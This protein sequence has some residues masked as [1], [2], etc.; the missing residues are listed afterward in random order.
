MT[1]YAILLASQF[2]SDDIIRRLFHTQARTLHPDRAGDTF[3]HRAWSRVLGAY[4]AIKTQADRQRW[5]KRNVDLAVGIC[6]KC[7]GYGTVGS[8]ALRGTIKACPSCAGR[9]RS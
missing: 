5:A 6:G 7:G 1:P 3:D 8:R 2:D 9:G 4:E